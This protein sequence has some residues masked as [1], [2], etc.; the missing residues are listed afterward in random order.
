MD[1]T[2]LPWQRTQGVVFESSTTRHLRI[3]QYNVWNRTLK[4]QATWRFFW[5]FKQKVLVTMRCYGSWHKVF[6]SN[7]EQV[8]RCL[9][10]NTIYEIRPSYDTL[11]E[12]FMD[13]SSQKNVDSTSL[14]W[15][16]MLTDT[17]FQV[18][19]Q[20]RLT[21]VYCPVQYIK[22]HLQNTSYMKNKWPKT[23]LSTRSFT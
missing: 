13:N 20:V 8:D 7:P 6:S 15:V 1:S 23:A 17:R 4:S 10:R 21:V 16:T 18:Q 19:T 2:W 12:D 14:P 22:W 9:L 3:A 5:Q 11:R